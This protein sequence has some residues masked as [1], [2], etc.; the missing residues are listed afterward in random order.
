MRTGS[1]LADYCWSGDLVITSAGIYYFP[2][3]DLEERRKKENNQALI[4]RLAF[5]ELPRLISGEKSFF[6]NLHTSVESDQETIA[7][8]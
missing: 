4:V 2:V 8:P 1:L 5:F 3:V 7:R 6:E